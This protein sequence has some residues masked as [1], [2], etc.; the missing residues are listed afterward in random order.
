MNLLERPWLSNKPNVDDTNYSYCRHYTNCFTCSTV[1]FFL[2][3]SLILTIFLVYTYARSQHTV[4][5]LISRNFRR[6]HMLTRVKDSVQ[7]SKPI[8]K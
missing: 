3:P 8:C 7:L 1:I 2:T 5:N 6:Y 4:N